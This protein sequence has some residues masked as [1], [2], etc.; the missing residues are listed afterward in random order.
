MNRDQRDQTNKESPAWLRD[1]FKSMELESDPCPKCGKPLNDAPGGGVA[2]TF[3]AWM[4][5][6]PDRPYEPRLRDAFEA[7]KMFAQ[8]E[9]MI[10]EKCNYEIIDGCCQCD[11]LCVNCGT[12]VKSDETL[13]IGPGGSR[14]HHYKKCLSALRTELAAEREK[15]SALEIKVNNQ[16]DWLVEWRKCEEALKAERKKREEAEADVYKLGQENIELEADLSATKKKCDEYR[17][18]ANKVQ[19]GGESF[20]LQFLAEEEDKCRGLEIQVEVLREGLEEIAQ[21]DGTPDNKIHVS[22]SALISIAKKSLANLPAKAEK[23]KAVLDA[24]DYWYEKDEHEA[25]DTQECLKEHPDCATCRLIEAVRE[26]R[27]K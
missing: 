9:T 15:V 10:C 2:M 23:V 11:R 17:E 21:A 19:I 8:G 5:S 1:K 3:D 6:Y 18:M 26:R 4:D 25:T 24:A 22:R 20:Q 27:E 7:G 16:Q 12:I 14:H 13:A